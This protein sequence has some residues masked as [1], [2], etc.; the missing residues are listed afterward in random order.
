[1]RLISFADHML[2]SH[3]LKILLGLLG[4]LRPP[5]SPMGARELLA[6]A[7]LLLLLRSRALPLR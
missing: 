6:K 2:V 4:S 3:M 5:V 1:M 7:Y